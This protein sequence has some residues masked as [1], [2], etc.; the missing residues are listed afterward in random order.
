MEDLE[1][2]GCL[3][4]VGHHSMKK[5]TCIMSEIPTK[6]DWGKMEES[7]LNFVMQKCAEH[8]GH[9]SFALV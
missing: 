2:C 6:K 9:V 8:W 4:P 5:V 1:E 7:G 3:D